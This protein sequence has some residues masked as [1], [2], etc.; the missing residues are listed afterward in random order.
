MGKP[1]AEELDPIP[2]DKIHPHYKAGV[3]SL[4]AIASEFGTSHTA[5]K[6]HA[7]KHGWGER[8][9]KPAILE[10][11]DALVA[12]ATVANG[13]SSAK[14]L[15]N[16][17]QVI[18]DNAQA[19]TIVRMGHRASISK[20]QQVCDA[21]LAELS[22][23][24]NMPEVAAMLHDVLHNGA[25]D[26]TLGVL[27]RMATLHTDLPTRLKLMKDFAEAKG[28]LVA[29]EREA[30]G[31]SSQGEGGDRPTAYIKDFTGRGD[32]DNLQRTP[33]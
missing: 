20:A 6:K 7:D 4:R 18:E 21:L 27:R 14:P 23:V 17:Q 25:D 15:P 33:S 3:R 32:P 28:R 5:I 30:F 2:W 8:D 11:S 1:S 9:L 13:V 12:K 24:V 29:L 19:L 16:E 31:L 26:E 10:R 22:A